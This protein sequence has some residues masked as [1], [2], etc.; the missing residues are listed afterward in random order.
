MTDL[1]SGWTQSQAG[2][3]R[4]RLWFVSPWIRR[5]HCGDFGIPLLV[6]HALFLQEF[7]KAGVNG[8]EIPR[9]LKRLFLE[10]GQF[11]AGDLREVAVEFG[12][13]SAC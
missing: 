8:N 11:A 10:C 12:Q 5:S 3:F 9:L 2:A 7:R 13:L 6:P 4:N 1:W